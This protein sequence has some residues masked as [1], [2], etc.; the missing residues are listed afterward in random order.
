MLGAVHTDLDQ[1]DVLMLC[2]RTVA[3][4]RS[5]FEKSGWDRVISVNVSSLMGCAM[6]FKSKL[7]RARGSLIIVSS[8]SAFSSNR[9]NPA[10]AASKA[11]AVS[12]TKTLGEAWLRRAKG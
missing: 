12:L 9:G 2:Q 1:L 3:Y 4:K 11:G 10:Y 6:K 8:V 7:A 5:E